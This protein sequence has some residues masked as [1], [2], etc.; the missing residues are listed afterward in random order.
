[1]HVIDSYI[2]CTK[3]HA[4]VCPFPVPTM[5]AQGTMLVLTSSIDSCN[6]MALVS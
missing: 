3:I 4:N 5:A 2:S 1:M 6:S